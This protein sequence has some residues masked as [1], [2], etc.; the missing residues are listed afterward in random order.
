MMCPAIDNPASC[1]IRAVIRFLHAETSVRRKSIV[2]Y[3]RRFKA[4]MK[5]VKELCDNGAECLKVANKCSR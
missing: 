1:E 4:Q 3:A 5:R 2:N